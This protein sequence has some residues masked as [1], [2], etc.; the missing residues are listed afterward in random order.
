[1][2]MA[3]RRVSIGISPDAKRKVLKAYRLKMLYFAARLFYIVGPA[4]TEAFIE[5]PLK[6]LDLALYAYPLSLRILPLKHCGI[7]KFL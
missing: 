3:N 4:L 6:E 1:M 7:S 2:A 5:P